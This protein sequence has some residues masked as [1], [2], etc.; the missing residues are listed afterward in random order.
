M[1][2]NETV[3]DEAK[4][5]MTFQAYFTNLFS[6]VSPSLAALIGYHKLFTQLH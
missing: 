2:D 4:I 5:A 3:E 6:L 1:T